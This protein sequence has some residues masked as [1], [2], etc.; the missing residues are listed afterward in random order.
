MKQTFE[1]YRSAVVENAER[2]AQT[3]EM[4]DREDH[5]QA[6]NLGRIVERLQ[7]HQNKARRPVPWLLVGLAIGIA[8]GR[9]F[10]DY[11]HRT[12]TGRFLTHA[13]INHETA[14]KPRAQ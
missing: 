11:V 1:E 8:C 12:F 14:G 7:N 3:Q 9:L 2:F 10:P 13:S 5:L 6:Y 4:R